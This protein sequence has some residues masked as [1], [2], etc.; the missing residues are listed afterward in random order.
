M[1][2]LR[3]PDDTRTT[4]CGLPPAGLARAYPHDKVIDAPTV[5]LD[6]CRPDIIMVFVS[7]LP[8]STHALFGTFSFGAVLAEDV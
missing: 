2:W 3:S 4:P 7:P 6:Q 8:I 1:L 5:L